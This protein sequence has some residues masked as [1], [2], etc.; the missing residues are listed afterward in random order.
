MEELSEGKYCENYCHGYTNNRLDPNRFPGK[1]RRPSSTTCTYSLSAK[2]RTR[3]SGSRT[4]A[5][6]NCPSITVLDQLR[7]KVPLE[8]TLWKEAFE[9]TR[10]AQRHSLVCDIQPDR[11]QH[12]RLWCLQPLRS[13]HRENFRLLSAPNC[14]PQEKCHLY[15]FPGSRN[16]C[17]TDGRSWVDS[18]D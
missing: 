13:I 18:M 3:G 7:S 1:H 11:K 4:G 8:S 15:C 2:I 12:W 10:L 6:W 16:S 5:P 14:N 9:K 17:H